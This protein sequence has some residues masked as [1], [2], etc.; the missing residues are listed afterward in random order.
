MGKKK[1]PNRKRLILRYTLFG[2]APILLILALVLWWRLDTDPYRAGDRV[3]GLTRSLE[4]RIPEDYPRVIFEDVATRA[5]LAFHHFN[6]P[7]SAQLPEDMGSGAAW[8]DYDQD[9]DLDL[10][11]TNISAPLTGGNLPGISGGRNQLFAN[12]GDGSFQDVTDQAGVGLR[13]TGMGAAWADLD[14]DADLDLVATSFG[15]L[16]LYMNQG[17]GIFAD[18]SARLGSGNREGFWTGASWADYDRDGDLDLYVCGY[19]RYVFAAEKVTQMTRQFAG[20]VPFTLNPSTY[21]PEENLLFRNRGN[22]TFE[23]VAREVGVHNPSGRSLAAAWCDLDQDGWLDLYIAN[24]VSD[25]VLYHNLG[26]GRFQDISHNAWVADY[27][28]AMGLALGD[29]D[30]DSD[31]DMFITHWI[32]QENALFNNMRFALGERTAGDKLLFMDISDQVGLGQIALDYVGWGTSFFDYNN[33]GLKDLMVINGSTFQE[34][35]DPRRLVPMRDQ[36]FWNRG[37]DDGFFEVGEVSGPTFLDPRV[38]RGAAFADY[39]D[40]GDV[41]VVVINHGD[42]VRLLQNQGGNQS[43]W[44]KVRIRAGGLN[45][46]GLG[47]LIKI[48]TEGREQVVQVGSQS[49]Y[50]SQNPAEAHFG[51]ADSTL[52]E[53]VEV[54]LLDG[55]TWTREQLGVNHT[56]VAEFP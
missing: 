35:L 46:F 31:F 25:N 30:N 41:D 32:A 44:L 45:H 13:H 24:D 26:E 7:R 4:R 52:I 6:S 43:N 12:Q 21:S 29:W 10:Y 37:E 55:R 56:L 22:G 53:R 17:D 8:G 38:G 1:L 34:E 11:L 14:G 50:L 39:D 54:R 18:E 48:R 15:R 3:E 2:I 19:V 49:S 40:D 5:G 42:P 16:V 36:L 33:D 47:A 23:E 28:G 20:L 27:R 9:G 51:L